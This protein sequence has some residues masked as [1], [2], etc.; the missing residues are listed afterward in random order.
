MGLD[1]GFFS[2]S[3][4]IAKVFVPQLDLSPMGFDLILYDVNTSIPPT[5]VLMEFRL[6]L[7]LDI[8]L[9]ISWGFLPIFQFLD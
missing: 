7:G 5:S 6:H 2:N 9:S 8:D 1:D 4:P 3:D